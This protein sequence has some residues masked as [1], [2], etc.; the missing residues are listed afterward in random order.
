[1]GDTL[2]EIARDVRAVGRIDAVPVLL[3]VLCETTGMGFAAVARVTDDTWTACAVHDAIAFGLLPGGQL[4]VKTTLC[5]ESRERRRPIVIDHAS[6]DPEYCGHH[7]PRIYKIESYV[8]VPIVLANDH[9]FGNLCAIDPRPAKVSDPRVVSMFGHFASLIA[10]HLDSERSRDEAQAAL[11][12]AHQAG[13]LR[14]QFIAILGHD[15]RTP[16]AAVGFQAE[17]LARQAEDGAAVRATASRIGTNVRR[18]SALIDDVLDFARGRLGGGIGLVR[19]PIDDCGA[20]LAAAVTEIQAAHPGRL[21]EAR[22]ESDLECVGDRGRLHQL[23]SNLLSNALTH[24]A[25]DGVVRLAASREEGALVVQVWNEGDPIA[26]ESLR[27]IF[28]PFR[29]AEGSQRREGLGLGLHICQQIVEAHGGTLG[30]VSSREA[31]T[32]FTARLPLG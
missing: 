9:Y 15:L 10:H 32:T 26:E 22:L 23:A 1:M 27:Q 30:V 25:A 6:T 4:D 14:D 24:G 5:S 17:L 7:T 11:L 3:R 19:E 12:D 13:E 20:V 18:M 29:R 31:G 28:K 8:S 16:L 21:V 2:E